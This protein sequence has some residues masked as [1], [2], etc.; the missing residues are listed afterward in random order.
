M[1]YFFLIAFFAFTSS[2]FGQDTSGY[3]ESKKEKPYSFKL[4][5]NPAVGDVVNIK[6]DLNAIK[7]VKVYN[8]FGKVVL[9]DRISTNVLNISRLVPGIY[10]LQVTEKGQSM[11]QK[12]VVK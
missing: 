5:P 7:V 2:V 4:Y 3:Q 10:V 12:L 8:V 6:S 9:T 11:T 1:K